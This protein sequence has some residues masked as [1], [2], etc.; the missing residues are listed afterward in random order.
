MDS[1]NRVELKEAGS[2]VPVWVAA[3]VLGVSRQHV[4]RLMDSGKLETVYYF[5]ARLVL[6]SSIE[7]RRRAR[8]RAGDEVTRRQGEKSCHNGVKDS[9]THRCNGG[10]I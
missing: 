1:A 6:V 5:G 9:V 3:A 2:F 10:R 4:Y 8:R 7:K